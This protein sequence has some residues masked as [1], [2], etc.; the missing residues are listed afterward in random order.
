MLLRGLQ[1]ITKTLLSNE[2]QTEAKHKSSFSPV[3]V[4]MGEK[5]NTKGNKVSKS[6][7]HSNQRD[8]PGGPVAKSLCSQ[9][10]GRLGSVS[11]QETRS[12]IPQLRSASAK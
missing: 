1:V 10:S 9:C 4:L 3:K 7:M 8:I 5:K 11:G 2:R 6:K 12:H